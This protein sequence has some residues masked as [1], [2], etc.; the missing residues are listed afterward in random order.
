[1]MDLLV[2]GAGV[3][4]VTAAREM[5]RKGFSVAVLE[6]RDRLGGRVH[7]D[8][9]FCGEPVEAGAEFIHCPDAAILPEARDAELDLRPIPLYRK[10]MFNIGGKTRWL[11]WVLLHPGCW[12]SFDLLYAI[13]RL[14]PPDLSA[15]EFI[16]RGRYRGRSRIMAE[17]TLTSH[18]PGGL[19]DVGVLGLQ[20]DGIL[21]LETTPDYRIVKGFSRLPEFI[22]RGLDIRFGVTVKAVSWDERGV[23]LR[24]ADGRELSARAAVCTVPLG[25]LKSG[26]IRF[27]PE[28]PPEKQAAYLSVD[29]GPVVKILLHFRERFW[30][31]WLAMLGC[32]T[33]PVDIYWPVFYGA[34]GKPPVITAYSTGPK[35]AELSKLGDED[36]RDLVITD[37]RRLF[38]KAD[39]HGQLIAHK[40]VDWATDPFS[41]G[42]YSFTRPGGVGGRQRLAAADT[43]ALFWAGSATITT[44]LT[45]SVE[46]AYL[47]GLRAAAEAGAH[48]AR[49]SR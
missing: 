43:G 27:H 3:A 20:Q 24:L 42:G 13:S 28:L 17:M 16:E 34:E 38:P 10:T 44:P 21:K 35:A 22:G 39:P 12:R 26:A 15:R 1:M 33:G 11:P 14:K 18:L 25:V 31:R 40:R 30:P 41:L 48:L 45:S 6:G 7:T 9:D 46:A 36:A 8:E 29:M 2:I 23:A 5:A 19:D 47:S 4:G 32:G 37:L 49:G